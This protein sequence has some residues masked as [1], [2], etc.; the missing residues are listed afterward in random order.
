M[1][2]IF[3]FILLILV[4]ISGMIIGA[5]KADKLYV[6]RKATGLANIAATAVKAPISIIPEIVVMPPRVIIG[7]G[8]KVT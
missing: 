2:N 1:K 8:G 3:Y 6:V 4:F 7:V 5:H